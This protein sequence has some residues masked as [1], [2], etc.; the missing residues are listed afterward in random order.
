MKKLITYYLT[1]L[2][3]SNH[4][5][6]NELKYFFL[7]MIYS[8]EPIYRGQVIDDNTQIIIEEE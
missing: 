1:V 6:E 7:N 2:Y 5:D 3:Q 4:I 8:G